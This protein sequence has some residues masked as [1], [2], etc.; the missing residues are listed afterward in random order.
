MTNA[1]FTVPKPYNEAVKSYKAGSKER[2]AIKKS[3]SVNTI[4]KLKFQL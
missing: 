2:K 3:L 1:V 4:I